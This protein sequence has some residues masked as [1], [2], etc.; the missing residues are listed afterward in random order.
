MDSAW[1]FG[2]VRKRLTAST[3]AKIETIFGFLKRRIRLAI[4]RSNPAIMKNAVNP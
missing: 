2:V 3:I 4:G 1:S